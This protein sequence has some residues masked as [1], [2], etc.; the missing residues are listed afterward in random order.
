MCSRRRAV[1]P[2]RGANC[3]ACRW[4]VPQI[5]RAVSCVSALSD[6]KEGRVMDASDS[7]CERTRRRDVAA[8]TR[9]AAW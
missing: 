4:P 2:G 8:T 6:W 3:T 9:E 5:A 7:S 1:R